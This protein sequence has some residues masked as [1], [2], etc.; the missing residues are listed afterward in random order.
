MPDVT[1]I[2]Q[3]TTDDLLHAILQNLEAGSVG[4]GTLEITVTNGNTSTKDLEI[5]DAAKGIILKGENGTRAR[6]TLNDDLT[7]T[8]TAL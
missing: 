4:A 8:V 1:E 2:Y 6:I 5:T 7:L 3:S